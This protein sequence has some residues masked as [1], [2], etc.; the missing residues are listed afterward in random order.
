MRNNVFEEPI[1]TVENFWLINAFLV[2][3]I[4]VFVHFFVKEKELKSEE[5]ASFKEVI[6]VV[7]IVE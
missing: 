4:T 7:R 6:G 2:L 3:G 1:L 5:S